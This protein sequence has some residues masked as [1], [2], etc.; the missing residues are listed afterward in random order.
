MKRFFI[1]LLVSLTVACVKREEPP[2]GTLTPEQM[3]KIL[4]D[5]H[6]AEAKAMHFNLRSTDS[7]HFFYSQLEKDVFKKHRVD[8]AT[9]RKSFQ[10]YAEHTEYMDEIYQSVIDSLTVREKTGKLN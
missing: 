2:P 6:L 1:A 10:F 5:V 7:I 4:I 9:Y 8:T 3:V